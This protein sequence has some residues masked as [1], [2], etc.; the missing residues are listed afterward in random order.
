[1]KFVLVHGGWQ[2]GWAWD[3]VSAL[4]RAG[5]HEVFAPTLRGLAEGA[6]DR[7]GVSL[8]DMGAGLIQEIEEQDSHDCVVV[9]H[10]GGGP[11]ARTTRCRWTTW[12]RRP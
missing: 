10:S 8:A 11:G 1:M 5:G 3:G 9:G 2:G 6:T 4:L 7:A 12:T